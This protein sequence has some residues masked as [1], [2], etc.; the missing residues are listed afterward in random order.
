MKGFI[1]FLLLLCILTFNLKPVLAENAPT[2]TPIVSQPPIQF[3]N[4]FTVDNQ[5]SSIVTLLKNFIEGFDSL[6]GGF[7]FYTP[8]PLSEKITLKD[9]SEIP[10]VTKYRN[11][12]Y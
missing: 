4:E 1:A 7:I 2:P 8:N 10:G 5:P 12:F 6:L 11:M 3:T 9:K